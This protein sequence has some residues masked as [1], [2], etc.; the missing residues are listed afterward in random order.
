MKTALFGGTFDP[1]HNGHLALAR[2][3]LACGA[4]ERVIFMP[5]PNPPHKTDRRITP[6]PIRWEML[7]LA[8]DGEK[9]ME[10]SDAEKYRSGR[11]YTIDTLN[12][13]S[14]FY[15]DDDILL[16]IGSDSLRQLHTWRQPRELVARFGIISYP[17]NGETV[18]RGEL[19]RH[20]SEPEADLLLRT[21]LTSVPRFPVSSTEIRELFRAGR[22]KDAELFLSPAVANYIEKNKVY[23]KNIRIRRG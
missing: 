18:S 22:Q 10:L 4:A 6:F 23:E 13:V 8:L 11:S 3:V 14:K 15:P 19:L 5:A 2:E 12:Q 7:T 1:V 21:V 17:R 9:G 20:W 16:L